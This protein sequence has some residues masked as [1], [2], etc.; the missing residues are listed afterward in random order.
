MRGA[1]RDAAKV[2]LVCFPH[3]GGGAQAYRS[4]AQ[5]LPD[6]IDVVAI[7][8]PGR[9]ARLREIA[10]ADMGAAVDAILTA[11]APLLDMP[12]VLFGHSAGALVAFEVARAME[13]GGY[14]APLRV[15]VSGY[16]A[17]E[18]AARARTLHDASDD[19]LIAAIGALGLL[20]IE[21]ADN[22]ELRS[23]LLAP[24][25]ADF[26]MC[27]RHR[28]ADEAR[29]PCALTA[30]GGREDA[31]VGEGD[32]TAWST[33]T[34]REFSLAMFD[35][36]HFYT[37]SAREA[38]LAFIAATVLSDLAAL[39]A[40]VSIGAIEDYPLDT[41]LHELFR[42][43]AAMSPE[44]AALV[45]ADGAMTFGALDRDSDL[46]AR[47]LVAA[48]VTVDSMTA[49][50]METSADFVVA[51]LAALKAGG[52]YLPIPLATPD[53]MIAEILASVKPKA[54]VSRRSLLERL[55][56][57]WRG[58]HVCAVLENGWQQSLR[59]GWLPPL[60]SIQPLPGPHSLAYAVMTSGTTGKPKGILCPHI[61]AVNSY[62]WR[63]RHLPYAVGEREACNVFFVWEV[64]RPL[65]QGRTA[66]VIPDDV[67]FDPRR[68]IAFLSEHAITRVLFT[69][70]LFEQVLA[71]L[72]EAGGL[73]ALSMVI[74]NGEVVSVALRDKARAKLPHV[75]LVNDYSISECHDVTT[76]D[77]GGVRLAATARY[78][79]A[80]RV[81]A[82]VRVYVLDEALAPVPW[83]VTGEIY[84]AGPNLAR[85]YLDL[86][87]MTAERFLPDPIQGGDA[88][89]FRT[90]DN[91]RLLADGQLEVKGRS[92]FMIKLR[93]YS[94]VL[95]AVE[96]AIA[97]HPEV[98]AAAVLTADDASTGQPDHLVGYVAGL[99]GAPDEALLASV[100]AHLKEVLPGYAIPAVLVPVAAMPIAAATGKIDRRALPKVAAPKL[101]R[102][103]EPSAV[104]GAM[105][106]MRGVW[107]EVLGREPQ[108]GGDNFFDLGGHSLLAIELALKAETAFGVR[109]DVVDVFD[110]PTLEAFT[111][112]V[113]A[114]IADDRPAAGRDRERPAPGAV[115]V[116]VIG[117]A[118]R[119]P[120]ADSPAALWRNLV[121]GVCSVRRL[122][123]AG[124]AAAGVGAELIANP[125]YVK[126]GAVLDDVAAFDPAFFGLSVREA[127]LMDPQQRLFIQCCWEAMERAG[128]APGD[129]ASRVGVFAGC[130]LPGYLVHHLGAA[131]HLDAADPTSFHLAELGNDKDY[132]ATR[133]AF[134]LDLD[135]PAMAVQTSCS[136]GLVAI[137]QAAQAIQAGQCDM[138]LAGA[139]SLTFPQ[140]GYL[141]VDGH[142]AAPDGVCRTF[143][144]AAGGTILGDGVGVVV[145]RRLDDALR[146]G[147]AVLAV[148]KGYA[149]NNDGARKA[150]FSAPSVRGQADVVSA[151]LA[152]AG[153]D[154]STIGYVE[155]H[156]TATPVGDPIEVRA[157]AQAFARHTGE[158]GFCA[159]GSIKPNIGHAN[160]AAGTA[161]FIKTVL[162]LQHRQIP[163]QIH[164]QTPNT[165]L[166]LDETPFVISTELRDFASRD[167]RA[168]RAGVSSFGIGGTNAHV[169]LEEG[170]G[171]PQHEPGEPIADVMPLSARSAAALEAMRERLARHLDAAGGGI[172]E[173][174]ATLQLGRQEMA[175]RAAVVARDGQAAVTALRRARVERA[176]PGSGGVVFVFPGQGVQHAG[177]G[178]ELAQRSP[179]FAREFAAIAEMFAP[180]TGGDLHDLFVPELAAGV[181][182]RADGLQPALFAVELALA[183][184]L[185]EWGLRPTAVAGHSLGQYVAA[186]VGGLLTREEAVQLVA[187]R[188]RATQDAGEGAMM[189]FA[190]TEAE[191]AGLLAAHRGVCVA[192]VNSSRD[193]VIAGT[194]EAV[195][196]FEAAA[197][198]R[199]LI[200]RKLA[201]KRAFHSPMMSG[202][203]EA[204][205]GVERERGRSLNQK[206]AS[207]VQSPLLDPF[208]NEKGNS[209]GGGHASCL[210]ACNVTGGWLDGAADGAYWARHVLEPV[211]FGE[212]ANAVMALKPSLVIEVGPGT[213]LTGL[214]ARSEAGGNFVAGMRH[215][216]DKGRTDWDAL[217]ESVA[218]AWEAGVA[219]DWRAFREGRTTRRVALPTYPFAKT[220]CWPEQDIAQGGARDRVR[221]GGERKLDRGDR[222]YV[223]SLKRTG[224]PE[225]GS[226]E[227]TWLVHADD[228]LGSALADG[229]RR[230]GHRATV[231]ADG[232][233]I[234]ALAA[235]GTGELRV[236]SALPLGI[237]G[238][239][240]GAVIALGR[241]MIATRRQ[242]ALFVLV[243]QGS[244]GAMVLGPLLS[245]TQ[246]APWVTA[247][248]I[249]TDGLGVAAVVS[250]LIADRREPWV[251]LRGGARWVTRF[252]GLSLGKAEHAAG[253]ARLARGPHII[254]GGTGRIG[255]A[256]AAYLAGL[257]ADVIV[258]SRAERM[259]ANDGGGR[260]RAVAGDISKPGEIARVMAG[261]IARH[262]R[263]GGVFH[264]AGLAR[265]C[266][267][268]DV[269][270]AG[271]ASELAP[272]VAG[273]R[274][275]ACAI[276]ELEAGN[277]PE[278]V[279]LF[280]SLA[281]TLGG[282]G[283]GPYAAANRFMDAFV[284]EQPV[285]DGVP[286][287]SAAW[288]DW[289]FDYGEAQMGAYA[290]TRAGLAI[291]PDE[292][293]AAIAAIVGDGSLH[294]VLI[295]ATALEP[296]L[297]RWTMRVREP[298][299]A[300]VEAEVVRSGHGLT[301]DERRVHAAYVRVLGGSPGLDDD[302]FSLG[303]DSLMA[304]QIVLA[305]PACDLRIADVFDHPS[306]RKLAAQLAASSKG[307]LQVTA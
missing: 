279:M 227:Q 232:D 25:R 209:G 248:V 289:A 166:R 205:R 231:V 303:G 29:V 70:S 28:I 129:R 69:P 44:A 171:D 54:I 288:D 181:L 37:Q 286:W 280:S 296:R 56:E 273:T 165:E 98:A 246:E 291:S 30:L 217:C 75:A 66:Y 74:L 140:G 40:S 31:L 305:L 258:V 167:G 50:V 134:L 96:A 262:G 162:A 143:D 138:A 242:I 190:A 164:F 211:R 257:G 82:N 260:I 239:D 121:N 249:E 214:M 259:L 186:V 221:R 235:T 219:V 241:A 94:V 24:M 125:D 192:A 153:V 160:I 89:M 92:G 240:V 13:R 177:M 79:P 304:T 118:C 58:A 198:G 254:T 72:P 52:A 106:R 46:L 265:L 281:A 287:I 55:P 15:M 236:V 127:T 226:A 216:G 207:Q 234:A 91:G 175:H 14:G 109:L 161:G 53:K 65:L 170:P 154:A 298:T 120:G 215:P 229:L 283:L 218:R 124:L 63:F 128:H 294:H 295:A 20:P 244:D 117:M 81:M 278:F 51:Y 5:G 95:S 183:R 297:E 47:W 18:I 247:R 77:T 23:L 108:A 189:Q 11:L 139:S 156:G 157:L 105:A 158:H 97:G 1:A 4:W 85:G 41:C 76:S 204:V 174:A 110:Y 306:V 116:A 43:Q 36:G 250:E 49:I 101:E 60:E 206:L 268:R 83:G 272:K 222:F 3:G 307:G 173:V 33:R 159:L 59:R 201:V 225:P 184:T 86:P 141:H 19:D 155:A 133:T 123:D 237:T 208:R 196:A 135:G 151:A 270:A 144:A 193:V 130:Y 27:E 185:I 182:T 274:H 107:R 195:A 261:C 61:G 264:A 256:L 48:G 119:F 172:G 267:I 243:P 224:G 194:V 197:K 71:A 26:A 2:R 302:F 269:T 10:F 282:L 146:D 292:G 148:I 102:G 136:T 238:V 147:D 163:P 22:A 21:Y 126:V 12:V 150:G 271:L 275:L 104:A 178:A 200:G 45:G 277:R 152:N 210:V 64:L 228:A 212:N 38:L 80:G 57:A 142:I 300:A 293:C 35:G 132:L 62:W 111:R 100:R 213:T 113:E 68:L 9:G 202:V 290:Q 233:G 93:G 199:G 8:P 203:A 88:R 99:D 180:L 42:R 299:A 34:D 67:I 179:A 90:G 137:A 176:P 301:A 114:G 245:L 187:A 220:R 149:V 112:H 39:P 168:R 191:L 284:A 266:E 253:A 6:C 263:I 276:C 188:A 84:V 285:R 255:Q 223:P 230:C 169:I 78:V 145:L 73:P 87:D 32:L 115:D 7:N 16:A 17:P 251:G 103:A 252:D 122:T 131:K